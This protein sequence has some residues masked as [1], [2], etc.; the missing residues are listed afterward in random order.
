MSETE[1]ARPLDS[2]PCYACGRLC[3]VVRLINGSIDGSGDLIMHDEPACSVFELAD[4][5][6]FALHCWQKA[7]G[8][9][10]S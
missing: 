3:R 10:P 1:V 4:P 6:A 7:K 2:F 5:D 9:V 8:I